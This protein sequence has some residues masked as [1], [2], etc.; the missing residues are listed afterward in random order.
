MPWEIMT[1]YPK[2]S[3]I[4]SIILHSSYFLTQA[5]KYPKDATF[6][7]MFSP[8]FFLNENVGEEFQLLD[9]WPL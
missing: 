7:E 2:C 5:Q 1:W 6:W 3:Q 4:G 8:L 9:V